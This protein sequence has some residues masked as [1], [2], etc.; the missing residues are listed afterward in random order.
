MTIVIKEIRVRTTIEK[1]PG[2]EEN[3][4]A[5]ALRRFKQ[6]ILE[7]VSRKQQRIRES[8]ENEKKER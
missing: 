2:T 1:N 8:E 6:E 3:I 7:E 4:S 5:E